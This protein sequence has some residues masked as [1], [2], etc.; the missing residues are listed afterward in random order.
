MAKDKLLESLRS[1]P[2]SIYGL[3]DEERKNVE[4]AKKRIV[5]S[6]HDEKY[7]KS[8]LEELLSVTWRETRN[9]YEMN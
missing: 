3:N 6:A 5:G 2:D 9:D 8:L 1:T 4:E 7:K